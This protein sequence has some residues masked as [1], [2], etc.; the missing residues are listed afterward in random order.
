MPGAAQTQGRFN[1]AYPVVGSGRRRSTQPQIAGNTNRVRTVAVAKPP[2]TTVASGHCTS[3]SV[4]VA[5][6]IGTK[7]SDA[8]NAV[9]STGRKA[10]HR[11]FEDGFIGGHAFLQSFADG[12]DQHQSIEHGNARHRDESDSGRHRERDA[13]QEQREHTPLKGQ[14][15]GGRHTMAVSIALPRYGA[16]AIRMKQ[17]GTMMASR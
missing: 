12:R 11:S 14:P 6:T 13:T 10:L 17:I 5:I 15:D 7:P 1:V 3:A 2:M 16:T 4:P 9:I 8:T